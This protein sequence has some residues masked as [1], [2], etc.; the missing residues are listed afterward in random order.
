MLESRFVDFFYLSWHKWNSIFLVH[1]LLYVLINVL[2]AASHKTKRLTSVSRAALWRMGLFGLMTCVFLSAIPD[3]QHSQLAKTHKRKCAE[4]LE[5]K[6]AVV[7][8][9]ADT[10]ADVTLTLGVILH[11]LEG[12]WRWVALGSPLICRPVVSVCTFGADVL[13][14]FGLFC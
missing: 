2:L 13:L 3:E 12:L 4:E 11:H 1:L 8:R 9:S 6:R 10:K 14:C 7:S 5:R